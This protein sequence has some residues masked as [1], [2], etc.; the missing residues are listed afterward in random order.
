MRN[1]NDPDSGSSR[2][3]AMILLVDHRLSFR[4][5]S[6][7]L[8]HDPQ[9]PSATSFRF[10]TSTITS[11]E[12]FSSLL[13]AGPRPSRMVGGRRVKLAPSNRATTTMSMVA[14]RSDNNVAVSTLQPATA[15]Q[16]SPL[17]LSL[18]LF[19]CPSSSWCIL[20][21]IT[22]TRII[23][24]SAA[25]RLAAS[26]ENESGRLSRGTQS[27]AYRA[28]DANLRTIAI[29]FRGNGKRP[30]AAVNGGAWPRV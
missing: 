22:S 15:Q 13:R 21:F 24:G 16:V 19:V 2:A 23:D 29:I 10:R 4:F 25:R 5:S 26:R 17:S 1:L 11:G 28:L 9:A 3:S 6:P 7:S 12:Y 14:G 20:A 30:A 18:S 8:S 27:I